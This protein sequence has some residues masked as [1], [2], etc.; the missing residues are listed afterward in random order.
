MIILECPINDFF[1]PY[2]HKGDCRMGVEDPNCDPREECDAFD[3]EV[4]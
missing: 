3:E 1:C 4:E 2:F